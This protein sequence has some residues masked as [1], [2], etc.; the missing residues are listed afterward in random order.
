[1]DWIAVQ[2]FLSGRSSHQVLRF[3]FRELWRPASSNRTYR[4]Y[5]TPPSSAVLHQLPTCQ[6][7][8]PCENLPVLPVPTPK[9]T[10]LCFL[11]STGV[12][13][14]VQFQSS[15]SESPTYLFKSSSSPVQ[16]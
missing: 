9:L 6:T 16:V 14:P 5:A 3:R 2:L 10:S 1:M 7:L 8:H 4:S 11:P 12:V 13:V 15:R